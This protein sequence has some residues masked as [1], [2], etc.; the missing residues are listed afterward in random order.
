MKQH[1]FNLTVA[2]GTFIIGALFVLSDTSSITANVVGYSGGAEAV[3]SIIG[4]V[5][6]VLSAAFFIFVLT[7]RDNASNGL[8]KLAVHATNKN[9]EVVKSEIQKHEL[10]EKYE[11]K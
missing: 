10:E 8:E 6:I 11:H 3:A 1:N 2:L 7:V 4:M 9:E 5:M